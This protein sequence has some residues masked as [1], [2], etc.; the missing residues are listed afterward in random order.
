MI[1]KKI[2]SLLFVLLF[3]T[4]F[5]QNLNTSK[6]LI[7]FNFACSISKNT[8]VNKVNRLTFSEEPIS[9]Q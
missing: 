3:G 4:T 6:S 8:K 1:K 7:S 9:I 5:A 2:M